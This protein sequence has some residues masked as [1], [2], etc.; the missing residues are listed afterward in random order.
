MGKKQIT[1][2]KC[3]SKFEPK[4][5]EKY[6]YCPSCDEECGQDPDYKEEMPITKE[7][8]TFDQIFKKPKT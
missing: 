7:K 6:I 8:L 4:G 5:T 3:G 1:C 2:P